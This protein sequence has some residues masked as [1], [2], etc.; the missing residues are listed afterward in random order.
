MLSGEFK[1]HGSRRLQQM[2]AQNLPPANA[3]LPVLS[4]RPACPNFP[5]RLLNFA[6]RREIFTILRLDGSS[7]FVGDN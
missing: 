7:R 5:T 1:P 6:G 4:G 2:P 3:P